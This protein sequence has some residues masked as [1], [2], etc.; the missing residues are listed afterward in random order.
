MW[1][2]LEMRGRNVKLSFPWG[3]IKLR[4]WKAPA[5]QG[6]ATAQSLSQWYSGDC[7]LPC[8]H[9]MIIAATDFGSDNRCV[10]VSHRLLE[11]N[12]YQIIS[13]PGC[14]GFWMLWAIPQTSGFRSALRSSR[15]RT[16]AGNI[17]SCSSLLLPREGTSRTFQVPRIHTRLNVCLTLIP[18]GA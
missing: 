3:C 12:T 8:P 10:S 17:T 2:H 13:G 1:P 6:L 15:E 11:L 4:G 16:A 14:L 5:G 9:L 18:T 7:S